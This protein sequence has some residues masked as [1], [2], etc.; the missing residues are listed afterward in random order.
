MLMLGIIVGL[1]ILAMV[2]PILLP[3]N[4]VSNHEKDH[5]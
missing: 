1:F 3:N 5:V 4:K 2:C